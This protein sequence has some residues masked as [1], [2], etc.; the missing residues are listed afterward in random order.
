MGKRPGNGDF[1][2]L[3]VPPVSSV[4]NQSKLP[5]ASF[6]VVTIKIRAMFVH[7]T[8]TERALYVDKG[9]KIVFYMKS[10]ILR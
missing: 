4:K 1:S 5:K 3:P 2:F 6:L 10:R 7:Q 9:N 8:L